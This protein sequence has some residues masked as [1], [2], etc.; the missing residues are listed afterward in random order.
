M[1]DSDVMVHTSTLTNEFAQAAAQA[2][3]HVRQAALQAGHPVVFVDAAGRYIEEWPNGKRF[4]IRFDPSQP[5]EVHRIVL[6]E[7]KRDA[8]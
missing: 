2:G 8:A 5:R 4:E 7:L 1:R 3:L 6:R